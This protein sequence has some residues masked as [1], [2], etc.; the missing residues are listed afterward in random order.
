MD[1]LWVKKKMIGVMSTMDILNLAE[2]IKEHAEEHNQ[3]D[4]SVIADEFSLGHFLNVLSKTKMFRGKYVVSKRLAWTLSILEATCY[5]QVGEGKKAADIIKDLY[6]GDYKKEVDDI[7]LYGNLAFMC[8]YKLARKIMS[9]AVKQIE[10]EESFEP[11]KAASAYLVLGEAEENLQKFVRAIKYYKRALTFI[12]NK[13]QE[14][15]MILFLHFKLGALH[16]RNQEN[17][18]AITYL[19][20]TLELSTETDV[21]IRINSLVSLGKMYGS[22]KDYKKSTM[23]LK[24]SIPMLEDSALVNKLV[25]AEAYTEMAYNYFDQ[26][27][28]DDAIPYYEK[29]ISIHLKNPNYSAREL[30]MI[31]MQ[32]AYCLDHK[33]KSDKQQAGRNY[34]K[35]IEQLEKT[36]ERDL[37]E[38]AIGD[39]I[40]FFEST[41]NYK[42]KRLYEHK[43]VK[44]TNDRATIS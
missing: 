19:Q 17:D 22:K 39:V 18:E 8:D 37:L 29:A 1:T 4:L 33:E 2:H 7:I 11:L 26:S 41:G 6:E 34:E 10:N 40:A 36:S 3:E 14:S 9:D 28:F 20:R 35:A 27:K 21:E 25:H 32:Y 38:S 23:Y 43:F 42:K 5:S 12:Q 31:Y 13:E 16:A 15:Q 44:M 30:G 24:K